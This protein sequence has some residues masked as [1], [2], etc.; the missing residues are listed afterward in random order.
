MVA[1]AAATA[2]APVEIPQAE[3][4]QP[5]ENLADTA[6]AEA[7]STAKSAPPTP[8]PAAALAA[9][10]PAPAEPPAAAG[11]TKQGEPAQ[12]QVPQTEAGGAPQR[13]ALPTATVQSTATAPSPVAS[14]TPTAQPTLTPSPTRGHVPVIPP[15]TT[16]LPPL[17]G[18]IMGLIL[19]G[20]VVVAGLIIWAI[21]RRR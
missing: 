20:V 14:S 5:A 2:V 17:P 3:Q 7:T 19:A 1:G 13:M 16:G 9:P 11:E 18:W 10:V 15:P 8:S 21:R 6:V 12:Q 4:A